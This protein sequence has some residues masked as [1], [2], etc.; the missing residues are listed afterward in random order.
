MSQQSDIRS[1]MSPRSQQNALHPHNMNQQHQLQT[2][3]R[4]RIIT[5]DS[6]S[7]DLTTHRQEQQATATADS[8]DLG[9]G[10]AA[11]VINV[12]VVQ[13]DSSSDSM[14]LLQQNDE[15]TPPRR[16]QREDE[17]A[18]P[19]SS[20][21]RSSR[22]LSSTRRRRIEDV[23]VESE[24]ADENSSDCIESDTMAQHLYRNTILGVRNAR[25]ARAQ[26]RAETA[27]CPVCAMFAAFLRHFI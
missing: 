10:G 24:H 8:G 12:E 23:A 9:G 27:Q 3:R 17:P 5:S 1:W 26:L 2:P 4:R 18:Q 14:V 16:R 11:A 19:R 22:H 13:L 25:H 21:R 6:S 15:N 7:P 20:H